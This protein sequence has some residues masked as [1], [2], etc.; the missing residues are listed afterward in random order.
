VTPLNH[1]LCEACWK[2]GCSEEPDRV[3]SPEGP[4]CMCGEPTRSGIFVREL[5]ALMRCQGRGVVHA[6]ADAYDLGGVPCFACNAQLASS[7]RAAEK[8]SAPDLFA[9]AYLLGAAE[10]IRSAQTAGGILLCEEHADDFMLVRDQMGMWDPQ[11]DLV[12]VGEGAVVGPE[13]PP[14]ATLLVSLT[15]DEFARVKALAGSGDGFYRGVSEALERVLGPDI[16]RRSG[17]EV[18]RF[19]V[20]ETVP[21]EGRFKSL[22]EPLS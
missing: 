9:F 8:G 13:R 14:A 11:V 2:R 7:R 16:A 18:M 5:P 20:V 1:L 15:A 4:C 6:E 22:R 17:G 21:P 19:H 12:V 3:D 10:G